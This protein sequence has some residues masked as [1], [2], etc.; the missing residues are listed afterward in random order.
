MGL[1]NKPKG[2][3]VRITKEGKFL[4]GKDTENVYDELTGKITNFSFK[5]D[6]FEGQ[7]IRKLVITLEDNGDSYILSMPF[8]SSYSSTVVS[9]LKNA[10]LTRE[11]T[12]V[13]LVKTEGEKSSRT[14]LVKQGDSFM[15][16]YYTKD[17]PHG[18]PMFK[19][20]TKK[21]GKVEWDK[22]DFLEFRENVIMNELL[23]Q[24]KNETPRKATQVVSAEDIEDVEDG[25]GDLPF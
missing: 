14:L 13:P 17:Q 20:V 3:Y 25:D 18:Q 5:D 22:D 1:Q 24:V 23:T 16:S 4:L 7:K 9:F 15:K 2:N 8:D 10:D 19:K 21:S 11:I 12:L 6:E